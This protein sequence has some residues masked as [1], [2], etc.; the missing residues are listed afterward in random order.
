MGLLAITPAYRFIDSLSEKEIQ[1]Q[2][3]TLL[4]GFF[5]AVEARQI[6][7]TCGA[8][9]V[10][11]DLVEK[12]TGVP[13]D[14][15]AGVERED[16]TLLT[17]EGALDVEAAIRECAFRLSNFPRMHGVSGGVTFGVDHPANS[18]KH[19]WQLYLHRGPFLLLSLSLSD[20]LSFHPTQHWTELLL[21]AKSAHVVCEGRRYFG[22]KHQIYLLLKRHCL[23]PYSKGLSTI[24]AIAEAFGCVNPAEASCRQKSKESHIG[25]PHGGGTRNAFC[26]TLMTS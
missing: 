16:S 8:S 11:V 20:A 12:E 22:A 21:E 7:L 6:Y 10:L 15:N 24:E 9:R 2:A 26:G 23:F 5:R 4:A 13:F 3:E 19:S 25:Y 18:P 17:K 14:D 1:S